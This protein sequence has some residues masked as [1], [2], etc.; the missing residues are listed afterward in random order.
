MSCYHPLIR[1]MVLDK[2]GNVVCNSDGEPKF[3]IRRMMPYDI[4]YHPD[5]YSF[6]Q[7][8]CGNCVGC[9]LDHSRQWA[10]RMLM[11]LQS[12]GCGV[13]VTLT[14]SDE[15]VP[16]SSYMDNNFI[17]HRNYT[18]CKKDLQGFIKRLRKKF[19]GK[20]ISYY[21]A[22]EYGE[23]NLRP[24]YHGI[25]FGLSLEDL[26]AVELLSPLGDPV[27]N[28]FGDIYYKSEI[29]EGIWKRGI[30]G[31]GKVTWKSCA[32]VS[33][34]V[35]KKWSTGYDYKGKTLKKKVYVEP[36]VEWIESN[37]GRI[38]ILDDEYGHYYDK[39]V[40]LY[41]FFNVA[42]E[43]S[44]MSLKP[45]I[46]MTYIENWMNENRDLTLFDVAKI[47]LPSGDKSKQLKIPKSFKRKYYKDSGD[48]NLYELYDMAA[49][50]AIDL[51][52]DRTILEIRETDKDYIEYLAD[53]ER[54]HLNGAKLL[55]R[56]KI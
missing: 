3:K 23:L 56:D 27:K 2:F 31:L 52:Y 7:I 42:K 55:K 43:F 24:H 6:M 25:F 40:D 13:F 39:E 18:L 46:G 10:D 19:K 47:S 14:Y 30:V 1:Q 54:K 34:Y 41:E 11:E 28:A 37:D 36:S 12:A 32:Y 22:G 26:K 5:N 51:G 20:R 44:I 21:C 33:R 38:Q 53:K 48:I 9:K 50:K 16:K 49:K 29:L 8:P 4:N 15:T 17:E 45:G 35:T